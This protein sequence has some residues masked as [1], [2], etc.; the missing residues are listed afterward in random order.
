MKTR[1]FFNLK[2]ESVIR[3]LLA[4]RK[5]LRFFHIRIGNTTHEDER[6]EQ[7]Q[8][9]RIP[10]RK[11]IFTENCFHKKPN[12]GSIFYRL[13][14]LKRTGSLCKYL[15]DAS[16]EKSCT[17]IYTAHISIFTDFTLFLLQ[18]KFAL[19]HTRNQPCQDLKRNILL[20]LNQFNSRSLQLNQ[21]TPIIINFNLKQSDET[22]FYY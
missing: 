9:M 22:Y 14:A 13:F 2:K 8:R 12:F 5:L 11:L 18:E 16:H 20:T 15:Q 6:N 1:T 19:V 10:I 17:T 7:S 4:Q 3:H 21:S